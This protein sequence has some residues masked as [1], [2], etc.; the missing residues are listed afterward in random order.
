MQAPRLLH[1]SL[2]SMKSVNMAD[3]YLVQ[4]HVHCVNLVQLLRLQKSFAAPSSPRFIMNPSVVQVASVTR[5]W[6]SVVFTL[7]EDGTLVVIRSGHCI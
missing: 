5:S 6:N 4:K 2:I 7:R 3:R 1:L